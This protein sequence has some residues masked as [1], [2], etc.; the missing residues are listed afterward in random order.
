[1]RELCR[2]DACGPRVTTRSS[3]VV[4]GDAYR[5]GVCRAKTVTRQICKYNDGRV[6]RKDAKDQKSHTHHTPLGVT[7]IATLRCAWATAQ[8]GA[9]SARKPAAHASRT[10]A[11]AR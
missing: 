6:M 9:T 10:R 4:S 8:A 5:T 3:T 2:S 7:F 1:M 11:A